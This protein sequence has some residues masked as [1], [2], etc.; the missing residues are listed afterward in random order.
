MKDFRQME[1]S[2]AMRELVAAVA[3]PREFSDTRES[4]LNRAARRAGISFRAAKAVFYAEIT[5]PR[6]PSIQLLQHAANKRAGTLANSFETIARGMESAD[7]NLY[8]EDILALIHTAR[9]LRGLDS[10]GNGE[11]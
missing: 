2:S 3:G 6:H 4:W 1:K 11:A 5:D 10:P 8:R 7:P 9:A